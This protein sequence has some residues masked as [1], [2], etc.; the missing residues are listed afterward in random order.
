MGWP[1]GDGGAVAG[2]MFD[3]ADASLDL[4]IDKTIAQ[5]SVYRQHHP[6]DSDGGF[7]RE[8]VRNFVDQAARSPHGAGAITM[9][10]SAYRLAIQQLEIDR[11]QNEVSE[12]TDAVEM[13]QAAL[14]LLW[15]IA[16]ERDGD[17]GG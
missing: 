12:L 17:H 3:S 15:A 10:L 5:L 6:G 1:G 7:I 8:L 4:V 16:D 2:L 14:E 9:G 13:R 11:L